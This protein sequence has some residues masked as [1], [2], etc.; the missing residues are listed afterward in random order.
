MSPGAAPATR[1]AP[2]TLPTSVWAAAGIAAAA[3]GTLAALA[4]PEVMVATT[5][6]VV[7]SVPAVW[8]LSS[9]ARALPLYAFV[10][11]LDIYLSTS[12][13]VTSTQALQVL[14]IAAW[15]IRLLLEDRRAV[16]TRPTESV[17]P[18]SAGALLIAYLIA[19]L[20][21]SVNVDASARSVV[22]NLGGILMATYAARYADRVILGRIGR[23]MCYGA[24][25]TA[26]YGYF[27]YARGGYDPI[28][29]LFSPFY[30]E[31]FQARGGGFAVVA[32]F[33][34]PNILAGYMLMV[35]PVSWASALT[36]SGLWR[37]VA[38]LVTALLLLGIL[39]LTFSKASWLLCF[40]LV[41]LWA[42][43]R[44]PLGATLAMTAAAIGGAGVILFLL[45][46]VLRT[47]LYIFP[48]S[49]EVS[50]DTRLGLW[51]AA[52]AAFLQRPL[53]GFGLEGFAAA[54]AD[55]RYG[56]LADLVRA[57]NMY[58]QALV[59]LG[60]VGSVLWWTPCVL[61]VRRAIA[62]LDTADRSAG[63]N[64]HLA[65]LLSAAA[66]FLY[67]LVETLNISNQYVNTSW[68]VMGL[69]AA[70]SHQ[71][72]RGRQHEPAA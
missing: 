30:T 26:G 49:R 56:L 41:G 36:A 39:L 66:F 3:I 48:D 13:R 17:L 57:H 50:V 6:L 51:V 18:Y 62:R 37:R 12:L 55:V 52:V 19:S 20:T 32:S 34:N 59:D 4:R 64:L 29:P 54:T 58:L 28:Y 9:P 27:Q 40:A 8:V 44:L 24:L 65:L 47:L 70:S 60:I 10:L 35:L 42:V 71:Q 67:G 69:L 16:R 38:W 21:W 7:L 31:P 5:A 22:R 63:A 2:G 61:I 15:M 23:A 25:V 43:A 46:P 72:L 33:A 1:W 68:L 14:M 53:L 11:P 45:E